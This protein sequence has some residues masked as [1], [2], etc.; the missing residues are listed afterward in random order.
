MS[1]A[2]VVVIAVRAESAL[3]NDAEIMP[4]TKH[5]PTIGDI[6]F[7]TINGIILSGAA[8]SAMPVC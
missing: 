3:E 5:M 1:I 7:D 6:M 2:R 8:G 4:S